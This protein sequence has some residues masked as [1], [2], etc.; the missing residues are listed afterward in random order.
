MALT[1]DFWATHASWQNSTKYLADVEELI[2]DHPRY[3]RNYAFAKYAEA[4]ARAELDEVIN[5][6]MTYDRFT[7]DM[8]SVLMPPELSSIYP[9]KD[10]IADFWTSATDDDRMVLMLRLGIQQSFAS[11]FTATAYNILP[12]GIKEKLEA[13]H[14]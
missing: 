1:K 9:D 2:F 12:Q 4:V 5:D 13:I 11:Q 6:L 10:M 8:Q 3:A 7:E 14:E